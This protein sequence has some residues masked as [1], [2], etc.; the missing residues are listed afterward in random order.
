MPCRRFRRTGSCRR[1]SPPSSSNR[2][3]VRRGG[4]RLRPFVACYP[5]C[6]GSRFVTA[7]G[8]TSALDT[9]P[10][11][12]GRGLDRHRHHGHDRASSLLDDTQHASP[13]P[14]YWP[15][16]HRDLGLLS[17]LRQLVPFCHSRGCR[18]T[19]VSVAECNSSDVLVQQTGPVTLPSIES[20][21][22]LRVHVPS[23]SKEAEPNRLLSKY[24]KVLSANAIGAYGSLSWAR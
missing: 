13:Q 11:V 2:S 8:F 22:S 24:P 10:S 16:R 1:R 6:A 20:L 15:N 23:N 14:R 21:A 19:L 9:T 7:A 12:A 4:Q 17:F 5:V 18:N 3:A